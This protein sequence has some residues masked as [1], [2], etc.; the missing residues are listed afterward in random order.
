MMTTTLLLLLNV[1][2]PPSG[3]RMFAGST[4]QNGSIH[5]TNKNVTSALGFD[6]DIAAL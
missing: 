4:P 6:A 3:A 2:A 1:K 5:C